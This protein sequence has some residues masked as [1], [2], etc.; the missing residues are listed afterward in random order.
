MCCTDRYNAVQILPIE[1]DRIA[2]HM[3]ELPAAERATLEK[4]ISA[5]IKKYGLELDGEPRLYTCP[6]LEA[7]M[8][9]AL[10]LTVKPTACLSFNPLTED[11]CDQEPERYERV[12]SGV[13]AANRAA[14]HDSS[15]HAIP[16][17]VRRA[18]RSTE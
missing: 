11:H 9:C 12:H 7:D 10:P 1:A 13:V 17:A 6:F 15:L 3:R 18:L 2:A 5:S 4:R 14:G 16:L 8:R